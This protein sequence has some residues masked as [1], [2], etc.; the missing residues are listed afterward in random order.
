MFLLDQLLYYHLL[1]MQNQISRIALSLDKVNTDL[2]YR[3]Q[4]IEDKIKKIESEIRFMTM[5]ARVEERT[6]L[7]AERER[8]FREG[9]FDT[10]TSEVENQ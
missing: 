8:A 1:Q 10:R 5:K 3:K 6:R 4:I 2:D 7:R 9:Y